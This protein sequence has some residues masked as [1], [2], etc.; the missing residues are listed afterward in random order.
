MNMCSSEH[1]GEVFAARE[2]RGLRVRAVV[3]L[4]R[5]HQVALRVRHEP[6]RR[7]LERDAT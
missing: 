4:D 6:P 2:L 3:A 1:L 5:V 7:L